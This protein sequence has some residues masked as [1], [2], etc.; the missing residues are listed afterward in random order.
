MPRRLLIV[1]T[2]VTLVACPSTPPLPNPAATAPPSP[3]GPV[4]GQ[5]SVGVVSS[6]AGP[7]VFHDQPAPPPD[8]AAVAGL[9]AAV[10]G[11]LDR[12]LTDLQ[13]GGPG[14]LA[15]VAAPGLLAGAPAESL[16]AATHALASPERPVT[17]VFYHVIVAQEGLPLWARVNVTVTS[18]EGTTSSG[19]VFTP[20]PPPVLI[21][22]QGV[23]SGAS[24]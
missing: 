1:L 16:A 20:G 14:L 6:S 13:G 10:V 3:P 18:A 17:N 7:I 12:H 22:A 8:D 21:A 15:E 24:P 23:P 19:F 4:R 9:A 5:A 11:W 2:A